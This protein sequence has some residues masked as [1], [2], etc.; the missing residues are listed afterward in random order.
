MNRR[1]TVVCPRF[2][3]VFPRFS[4][5]GLIRGAIKMVCHTEPCLNAKHESSVR[6]S[7]NLPFSC[8]A[9]SATPRDLD[10]DDRLNFLPHQIG[11]EVIHAVE[12][13]QRTLALKARAAFDVQLNDF[14]LR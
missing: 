5:Q 12:M 4:L 7:F 2:S 8:S 6:H 10:F 14:C 11:G 1:I 9:F 3:A 13:S